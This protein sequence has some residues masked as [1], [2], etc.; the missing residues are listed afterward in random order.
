MHAV[1][2]SASLQ[3]F[4][5]ISAKTDMDLWNPNQ[6]SFWIEKYGINRNKSISDFMTLI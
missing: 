5:V 1:E 3:D 6:G 4:P 2:T